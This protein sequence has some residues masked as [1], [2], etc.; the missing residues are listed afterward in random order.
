MATL[1]AIRDGLKTR[2]A[3]AGLRAHDVWPDSINPPA[4]LVRP[5][6]MLPPD[7]MSLG[8]RR[9]TFEIL[10][11]VASVQ[12]A[13]LARAQEQLDTYL[14]EVGDKSIIAALNGD[15][16]LGGIASTLEVSWRDYG[17]HE[18]PAGSGVNYSA[19]VF[20]VTVWP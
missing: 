9:L 19:A 13:G 1:A 6:A 3:I 2:L 5:R 16:T 10:L 8:N 4:A 12:S 20:D 14:N 11:V 15:R 18:V 17:V 7:A